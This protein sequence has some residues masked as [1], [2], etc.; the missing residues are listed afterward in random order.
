MELESNRQ[1]KIVLSGNW[2]DDT[3]EE[4]QK[5]VGQKREIE[6]VPVSRRWLGIEWWSVKYHYTAIVASADA[7]GL[8]FRGASPVTVVRSEWWR[9]IGFVIVGIF[10]R[11]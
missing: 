3:I 2:L 4:W 8:N 10:L 11:R 7:T 1:S 9:R 5:L 6:Y